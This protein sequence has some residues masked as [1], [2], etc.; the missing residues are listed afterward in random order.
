MAGV[1]RGALREVVDATTIV[2]IVVLNA[3]I[4]S[5]QEFSAET[6]IA[7]LNKITAG[8]KVWRVGKVAVVS[9]AEVV[10][11]EIL[12]LEAGDLVVADARALEVLPKSV[13]VFHLVRWRG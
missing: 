4:G 12:E 11:G 1:V 5:Y 6:S 9:S 2:A 8:A 3:A 7:A 10:H 13:T